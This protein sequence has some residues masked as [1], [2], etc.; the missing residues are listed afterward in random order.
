M[1]TASY[2]GM[3]LLLHGGY[4]TWEML[5]IQGLNPSQRTVRLPGMK[6]HDMMQGCVVYGAKTEAVL[7]GTRHV[8]TKQHCKYTTLVAVQKTCYKKPQS[9][10]SS[11]IWHEHSESAREQRKVLYKN[12][13]TTNNN[14]FLT[15]FDWIPIS[16]HRVT[17]LTSFRMCRVQGTLLYMRKN[18]LFWGN[19]SVMTRSKPA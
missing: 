19:S 8:K 11:H 16:P 18:F 2:K 3:P 14:F 17:P 7:G 1:S 9:L 4:G 13:K 12:N 6:W 5:T 15:P 10:I